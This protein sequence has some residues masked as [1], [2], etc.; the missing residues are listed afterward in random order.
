MI[1]AVKDHHVFLMAAM[2]STLLPNFKVIQDHLHKLDLSAD[3]F[4]VTANI[5]PVTIN[6]RKGSIPR[7]QMVL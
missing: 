4:L 5:H 2:K 1:Q 7:T 3:T 6:I